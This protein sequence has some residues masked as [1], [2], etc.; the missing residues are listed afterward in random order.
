MRLTF[1]LEDV[2]GRRLPGWTV[3]ER[4]GGSAIMMYIP[5]ASAMGLTYTADMRSLRSPLG[6]TLLTRNLSVPTVDANF[7][8]LRFTVV[9]PLP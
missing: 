6:D 8:G 7:A 1:L 3:G 5:T 9:G 4:E 2:A